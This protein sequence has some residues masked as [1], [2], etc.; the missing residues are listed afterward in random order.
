ML[1]RRAM[2]LGASAIAGCASFPPKDQISKDEYEIYNA[3]W[4]DL[5]CRSH[6][7][8][9][10]VVIATMTLEPG[11]ISF[12]AGGADGPLRRQLEEDGY[13][14]PQ[15]LID[16]LHDINTK[17]FAIDQ[18]YIRQGCVRFMGREEAQLAR[19]NVDAHKDLDREREETQALI[20][21]LRE[22]PNKPPDAETAKRRRI[23]SLIANSAEKWGIDAP[24]L[25]REYRTKN[26][27]PPIY[28]TIREASRF[29]VSNN[30]QLAIGITFDFCGP[31]CAAKN[32]VI[33]ARNAN[34]WNVP[35]ILPYFQS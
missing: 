19:Q 30:R 4:R 28:P 7:K 27:K 32:F 11:R 6:E 22:E 23:Q 31:L 18:S 34:Q 17:S 2:I 10:V 24:A 8:L 20:R 9:D 25:F 12:M 16:R 26:S 15:E 35:Y 13:S 3:L 29:A 33:A 5:G 14:V 21:Q 1:N